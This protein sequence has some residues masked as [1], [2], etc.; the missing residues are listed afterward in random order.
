MDIKRLFAAAALLVPA[1]KGSDSASEPVTLEFRAEHDLL[2]SFEQDSGFVP[3]GAPAAI[4]VVAT[5]NAGLTATAQATA[6]GETLAPVEGSGTLAMEAGFSLEISARLDAAGVE[7]EGVVETFEYGIDPAM[8]TFEPFALGESVVLSSPLP[9]GELARVP[10]PSVPGAT[11]VVDIA[12]GELETTYSGVCATAMDGLAQYTAQAVIAGTLGLEGTIEVEIP[13]VGTE[14]FGPFAVDVPIPATT[15]AL[16][17]GTFSI[18]DGMPAEGSPCAGA[19]GD[20]DA[21]PTNGTSGP[22]GSDPTGSDP[23]GSDPTGD[24]STSG[25]P[26]GEAS[27]GSATGDPSGDD[28]TTTGRPECIE[29]AECAEDE[30]CVEGTCTLV[31]EA[32][33]DGTDCGTCLD[34]DSCVWCEQLPGNACGDLTDACFS[35]V[36]CVAL[37]ECVTP[38][39][40]QAC[41]DACAEGSTPEAIDLYNAAADCLIDVC[42]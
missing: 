4:R 7:Y 3:E 36:D 19:T 28:T 13:I 40:D 24:A 34:T 26:T 21:D 23:T 37:V 8:T 35:D 42:A 31:P 38:C 9:P 10:I 33:W 1:C 20:T 29:A 22:T 39:E 30:A 11:L 5:A 2:G 6:S 14:T 18:A 25:D 27:S 17:L 12:S 41:I 32:C 15:T 16:D